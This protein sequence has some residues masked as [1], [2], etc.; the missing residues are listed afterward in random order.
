VVRSQVGSTLRIARRCASD[1]SCRCARQ[2]GNDDALLW[3]D[4]VPDAEWKLMHRRS[5]MLARSCDDLILEG[6]LTDAG[7]GAADLLDEAVAEARLARFVSVLRLRDVGLRERRD[8][9]GV[10]QGAG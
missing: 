2:A 4:A 3:L 1:R 10:A 7:E 6:I 5:P 8:S 9:D